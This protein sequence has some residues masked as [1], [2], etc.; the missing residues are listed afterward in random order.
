MERINLNEYRRHPRILELKLTS[1]HS[2]FLS[3]FGVEK[4]TNIFKGL[5][6]VG[7]INWTIISS[8]I[9]RKD[10]ITEISKKDKLRY[11]QEVVFMG[12]CYGENRIR[13]GLRYLNLTKRVMYE[14]EDKGLDVNVFATKTWL[15]GLDYTLTISGVEAYRLEIERFIDFILNLARV[16]GHVPMAEV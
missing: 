6:D 9:N 14:T 7:R 3:E 10:V 5:C 12:H 11:R 8:I 1:M 2:L 4:T 16:I 13:T 15:D